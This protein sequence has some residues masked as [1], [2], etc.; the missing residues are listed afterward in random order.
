MATREREGEIERDKWSQASSEQL[1]LSPHLVFPL[2][3]FGFMGLFAL[4][5][6]HASHPPPILPAPELHSVNNSLLPTGV[7][8]L[9]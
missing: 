4:G 1:R 5:W 7:E 2:T 9:A 8:A 6:E 3:D